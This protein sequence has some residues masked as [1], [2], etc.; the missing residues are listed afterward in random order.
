MNE[1]RCIVCGDIVPE[2][3]Q[4][5]PSC[6]VNYHMIA[7]QKKQLVFICSPYRGKTPEE[8][9]QNIIKA[10]WYCR[11]AYALGHIPFA[12]HLYF[13]HF[14][15]DNCETERK[16]GMAMGKVIMLQCAE[17]WVCGEKISDGMQSEI[18][19]AKAHSIPI[20]YFKTED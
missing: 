12:P 18:T 9:Q 13:T 17:V 4:V 15:L 14:L 2:G 20:K 16:D 8:T 6:L 1:N 11:L 7:D 10:K 5:C 19:Y 3:R